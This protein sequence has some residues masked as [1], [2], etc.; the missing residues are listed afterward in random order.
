[1]QKQDP[2]IWPRIFDRILTGKCPL[3]NRC[4]FSVDKE[5]LPEADAV[6]FHLQNLHWSNYPWPP[7]S[8]PGQPWIVMSYETT[9][10]MEHRYVPDLT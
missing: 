4:T 3:E 9:P 5:L 8:T 10:N 7:S 2:T 6:L 1:M